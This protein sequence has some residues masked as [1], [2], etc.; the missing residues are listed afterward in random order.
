MRRLLT[1]LILAQI[2]LVASCG[3]SSD[4]DKTAPF[5]GAW[6]VSTGTLK[7]MCQGLPEFMQPLNGGQQTITKTADGAISM[8]ILEGCSIILDVAGSAA[9]LRA[10]TPPQSCTFPFMFMGA[11]LPVMAT[12]TSGNFTV[13][14]TSA[15]FNYVGNAT[16][17]LFSCMVT[18]TGLSTKGAVDAGAPSTAD[19]SASTPDAAASSPDS[20]A[21]ADTGPPADTA[22]SD[23]GG[24]GDTATTLADTGTAT[25]ASTD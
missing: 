22:S 3:S 12:F 24:T 19:G 1:G 25:D 18:G 8:T 20:G 7:A 10:T 2:A 5:V 9:N 4:G 13:N 21:T 11:S 15:A 6:T 14:G 16:A 23:T 17:G